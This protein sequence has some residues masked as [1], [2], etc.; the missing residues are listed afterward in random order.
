MIQ[1][2]TT[3]KH[4]P[5]QASAV[6]TTGFNALAIPGAKSVWGN[7]ASGKPEGAPA[8]PAVSSH[9]WTGAE[10]VHSPTSVILSFNSIRFVIQKLR[11]LTIFKLEINK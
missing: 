11:H 2:R 6:D 1:N 7:P 8:D 4:Q 10:G 9:S 5:S 3:S